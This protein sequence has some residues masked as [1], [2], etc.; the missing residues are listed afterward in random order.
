MALKDLLWSIMNEDD[1]NSLIFEFSY[2][3]VISSHEKIFR[4]FTPALFSAAVFRALPKTQ[5]DFVPSVL[6]RFRRRFQASR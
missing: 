5:P 2:L 4:F 3:H 6:R 1:K